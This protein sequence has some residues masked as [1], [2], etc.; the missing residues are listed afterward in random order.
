L[1]DAGPGK[2]RDLMATMVVVLLLTLI[3]AGVGFALGT[4]MGDKND[5]SHPNVSQDQSPENEGEISSDGSQSHPTDTAVYDQT[6]IETVPSDELILAS[7]PAVLTTLESPKGKWIR[8]EG[9]VVIRK[10][11]E[12]PVELLAE[13]AAE[14]ILSYLRSV[15]LSQLESPSGILGLRDDLDE[16]VRTLSGGDVRGILIHGLV[17]E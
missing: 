4:F 5:A 10:S 1:A 13:Q 8:M 15:T 9:S 2:K 6:S 7:F 11:S 3:G 17:I 12:K 14:Q 16:T